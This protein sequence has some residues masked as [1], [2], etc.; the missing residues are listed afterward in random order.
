MKFETN[1]VARCMIQ[2]M[3]NKVF[4]AL[5][6]FSDR[7]DE[8]FLGV[9]SSKE[10]AKNRCFSEHSYSREGWKPTRG[11]I[12]RWDNGLGIYVMIIDCEI[13]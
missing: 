13:E 7:N 6:G 5:K 2:I 12:D 8:K 11:W 10:K 9:F 4:V 3:E 1:V